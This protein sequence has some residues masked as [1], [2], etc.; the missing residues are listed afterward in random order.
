MSEPNNFQQQVET[1]KQLVARYEQLDEQ[2]DAFLNDKKAQT[3]KLLN[4][5]DRTRYLEMKRERDEVESEMRVLEEQMNLD[6]ETGDA[7]S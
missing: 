2:I 7:E 4:P 1:Y 5:E 3:G 6:D